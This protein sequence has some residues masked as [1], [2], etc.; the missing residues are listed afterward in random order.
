[1]RRSRNLAQMSGG[2]G[3]PFV[4]YC[5]IANI[6]R[7]CFK[8]QDPLLI[9]IRLPHISGVSLS[10]DNKKSHLIENFQEYIIVVIIVLLLEMVIAVIRIFT[11]K[12]ITTHD[13]T[14]STALI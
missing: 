11:G 14:I 4:P 9:A 8:V 12:T 2:C 7:D 6:K 5:C 13:K 1:M 10:I 3:I